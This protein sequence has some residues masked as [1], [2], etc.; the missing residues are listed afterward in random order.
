MTMLYRVNTY[1]TPSVALYE[2]MIQSIQSDA[3]TQSSL[4]PT[5]YTYHLSLDHIKFIL[6][7]HHTVNTIQQLTPY[8]ISR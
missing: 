1:V 6:S 2:R 7:T 4:S 5:D 3:T 8:T